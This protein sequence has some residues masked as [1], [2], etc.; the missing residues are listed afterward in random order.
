M[1]VNYSSQP[2]AADYFQSVILKE[3]IVSQGKIKTIL[4]AAILRY[5]GG[6][7]TI[8]FVLDLY[9]AINHETDITMHS[10]LLEINLLLAHLEH[11]IA[12]KK[13][14]KSIIDAKLRD[15]LEKLMC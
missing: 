1:T 8:Q 3:K 11:Q 6:L 12:C 2:N 15:I 10:E 13:S 4:A 7:T 14:N 5:S 9:T